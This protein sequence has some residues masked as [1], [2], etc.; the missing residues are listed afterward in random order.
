[1]GYRGRV[2]GYRANEYH[3]L[4]QCAR[5]VD[6][7]LDPARPRVPGGGG[8]TNREAFAKKKMVAV[9]ALV[10]IAAVLT[11]ALAA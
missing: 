3:L 5:F 11:Y 10:V 6:A 4:N 9:V 1:M 8:R 7:T 2:A